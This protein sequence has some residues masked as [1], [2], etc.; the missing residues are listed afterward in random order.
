MSWFKAHE[1]EINT[2]KQAVYAANML[3][4]QYRLVIHTW[5][6]ISAISADRTFFVIKPSGVAYATMQ[7]EDMVVMDLAGNVFPGSLRPSTDAPTHAV[8]YQH[9]KDVKAIVHTHSTYATAFA[10]AGEDIPC[11]GTTHADNFHGAVP[12]LRKLSAEEIAN[13]Y[14]YNTGKVI[15][16]EL[17]RRQID[18]VA[19][20]A[21]LVRSH[22]PFAWSTKSARDAADIALTLEQVAKMAVLTKQIQ[23]ACTSADAYLVKK[24]YERKHGAHAYYGQ[25][26]NESAQES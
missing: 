1:K 15:V 13:A 22:G 6:N 23:P 12:C 24:H 7:P 11:Y 8:L 10:Q 4:Q 2:L 26:L 17:Q 21:C 20:P 18:Y 5:G 9:F 3:L 14:E 25:R 16:A 19:T